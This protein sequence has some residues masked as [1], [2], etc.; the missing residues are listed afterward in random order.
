M[1]T[2]DY[3]KAVDAAVEASCEAVWL[4]THA[5]LGTWPEAC[6]APDLWRREEREALLP[7]LA[8]LGAAGLLR[9]PEDPEVDIEITGAGATCVV[10]SSGRVI[11]DGVS[12]EALIRTKS[13]A[14]HDAAVAARAW[15]EGYGTGVADE[16]TAA[17][18]NAGSP[19]AGVSPARINPY[20]HEGGAS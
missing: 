9:R 15:D 18:Y 20:E 13:A 4:S 16:R 12:R 1:K 7:A 17:D 14:E 19:F 8:S 5:H 10:K 2:P 11:L 3:D 6:P